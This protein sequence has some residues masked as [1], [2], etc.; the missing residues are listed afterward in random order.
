[1]TRDGQTRQP[2]AERTRRQILEAGAELFSREGYHA[3][4]SKKIARAAGISVGS[5]YNHFRD[6]KDLLLAVHREHVEKV[7]ETILATLQDADFAG[8]QRGG[9][10]LVE[11]II[12]QTLRVH[13][14]SPELH[15][16]MIA[17]RYTDEDVARVVAQEDRRVA[18]MLVRMLSEGGALRVEDVEA[19]AWVVLA[20]VEEII[21]SIKMS[22]PPIASERL[23]AALAEMVHRFL[24]R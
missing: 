19:A 23:V 11:E 5:F 16:Q 8:G 18:D 3:T 9:R 24:Y 21:H 7:H 10:A 20:S 12:N 6:K 4:S 17:L 14:L 15:R 13:S 2:R 1:M 22:E